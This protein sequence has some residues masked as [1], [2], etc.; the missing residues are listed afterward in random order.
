MLT[1]LVPYTIIVN[2]LSLFKAIMLRLNPKEPMHADL[3]V[4]SASSLRST[5]Q[6]SVHSEADR[7]YAEIFDAAMDR[8]LMPGAK[9]TEARLCSIF[10]C[11]RTTVRAALAQLA[12]DRIVVLEP[13]RGA[14]VWQATAKESK[15]VF[16]MRR[17]LE[18]VVIDVLLAQ[19][20]MPERLVP[21]YD[22]VD[23]EQKAFEQGDRATWIRLSNAFHVELARLVGND[24]LTGMLHTLCA[25]TSLIIAF[26]D[27]PNDSACSYV[28]HRDIL[29]EL[30]HG[31]AE[32]AHKAMG[33]HLLDCE[34]RM[35]DPDRRSPDPWATFGLKL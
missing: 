9:L 19:P 16:E 5:T 14:Y 8:R 29:D 20:A 10:S 23:R 33:H 4:S 28:E 30:A 25:R 2:T 6:G 13:N 22:M 17:A 18:G 32:G 15:D 31:S 26:H 24:V 27:T 34:Q 35:Q 21:L 1:I 12:H 7:V 3:A 11:S